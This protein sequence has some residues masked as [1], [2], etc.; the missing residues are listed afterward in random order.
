MYSRE[1]INDALSRSQRPYD[2]LGFDPS[3]GDSHGDGSHGTHVCSIAAGSRNDVNGGGVAPDAD[4]AFVHLSQTSRVLGRGNLGTA[5]SLLEAIDWLFELAGDR[6]CVINLSVG[7]HS[8]N[9]KGKS[10]VELGMDQAVWL[11]PGR[12]I[13][14]SAGNYREKRSHAE[15]RVLQ[16]DSVT[17]DFELPEGDANNSEIEIFYSVADRFAVEIVEPGGLVLARTSPGADAPFA[18]AIER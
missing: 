6:S 10:L 14:N 13:V 5:A 7:A 8:G 16:D 4:I 2:M 12:A 17:L 18:W 11:A 3:S 15:G 9:H 1:E